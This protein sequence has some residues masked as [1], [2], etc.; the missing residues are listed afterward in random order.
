MRRKNMLKKLYEKKGIARLIVILIIVAICLALVIVIPIIINSSESVAQKADSDHENT[1]NDS[2]YIEWAAN[3]AFEAVYDAYNK[4]FI[5]LDEDAAF[6]VEGYGSSK[7]NEG[8]VLVVEADELG[9]TSVKW[10]YPS[11]LRR[12]YNNK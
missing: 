1:A 5:S 10:V 7:E 8:K 6:K 12:I 4:K 11:E 9:N 2:A 3:G